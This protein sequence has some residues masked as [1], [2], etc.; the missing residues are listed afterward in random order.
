MLAAK[1][2]NKV[3]G[4]GNVILTRITFDS[5]MQG[6]DVQAG[7]HR[8]QSVRSVQNMNMGVCH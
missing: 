5:V 7:T 4:P 6:G 8:P 1:C 2:D 3:P